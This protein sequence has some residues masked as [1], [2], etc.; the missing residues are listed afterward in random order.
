MT[1]SF[2]F[3]PAGLVSV[4]PPSAPFCAPNSASGGLTSIFL[5]IRAGLPATQ[6]KAGT[7]LVTTLPAP[8][9]TPLPIVI[10][11]STITLPPNQQS[12]PMVIGFPSSGPRVP[13]RRNG[14]TGCV[15]AK[16]EQFG[17]MSVRDPIVIIQVSRKV[18]FMLMYTFC[19]R[20]W[21]DQHLRYTLLKSKFTGDSSR[22]RA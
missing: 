10:P 19:P 3:R 5:S 12:S 1:D 16:N 17:P 21:R 15:A 4:M 14:S 2:Y 6:W 20:L 18:Q 8:T 11:A 9:V 13:L 22:N 7:S